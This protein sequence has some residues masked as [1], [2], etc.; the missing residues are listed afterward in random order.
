MKNTP[1]VLAILDGWGISN[2]EEGNAIAQAQIPNYRR[3]KEAYPFTKL[4]CSGEDV[5]LPYGQMGNSEVGHLNIGAGRIVYQEL[6]RITKSIKDGSF[7][8]N[9]ELTKAMEYAKENG[10]ALH[11]MG[12]VSDGGVHSHLDHLYAL[13]AMAK[14]LGL[15]EVYIHAFLDGRDV[16]PT[17]GLNYIKALENKCREMEIGRIATVAGRYYAMDR[18]RRW[19]RVELAYQA[20]VEGKGKMATFAQMAVEQSYEEGVTDEFLVPTVIIDQEG[21]PVAPVAAEDAMIFFNFRADRAR[22]I[23]RAFVDRDFTEFTRP[24]GFLDTHYLCFTQYDITIEAPVAFP[25]QNLKNTL[26]ELLSQ[27]N[28]QQLRIAETEKYAHVTF[29][30]NG[31]VEKANPGEERILIPSPQVATYNLKPEMSAPEV[32]QRLIAELEKD[33]YQVVI[34]NYANPDMVGHTGVLEAT[35]QAVEAV[36]QCLGRLQEVILAKGGTLLVTADHG[37]AEQM[38]DGA[39]QG[40]YTAH[41]LNPVPFILVSHA[42]QHKQLREGSL[43]DISPTILE[44]LGIEQPEEMTGQ[45]LILG[46][47]CK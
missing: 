2:D 5:G 6:T 40:P 29:F 37:N 39:T 36:D 35:I 17:S 45:S 41:T 7:F 32:T 18:D 34:L 15:S 28:I 14:T 3:M 21:K 31:G 10:R 30:F 33:Q 22:E 24:T 23:T 8:V 1:L 9:E 27:N 47:A 26:G 11:L 38:V 43:Q 19:E 20:M 44:L 16:A 25:P 46:E 4:L 13:L 12:L 42:C